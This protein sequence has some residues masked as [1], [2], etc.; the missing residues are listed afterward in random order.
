MKL[1]LLLYLFLFPAW[2]FLLMIGHGFPL[3]E[4]E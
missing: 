3:L 2:E 4:P 1:R